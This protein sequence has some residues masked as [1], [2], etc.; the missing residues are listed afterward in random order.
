MPAIVAWI[1][2]MLASVAGTI[3]V[4]GVLALGIGF[5]TSKAFDV[6]DVKGRIQGLMGQAGGMVEWVGFFGLDQAMTIVLSA[7]AARVAV[8]AAKAVL[9]KRGAP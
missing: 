6:L 8:N 4:R 2:T 5:A 3:F 7:L 9:V 1:G